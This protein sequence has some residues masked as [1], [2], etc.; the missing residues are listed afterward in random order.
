M[1]LNSL[2]KFIV[3]SRLKKVPAYLEDDFSNEKIKTVGLLIDE[4]YFDRKNELLADLKSNGIKEENITTVLYHDKEKKRDTSLASFSMKQ[5]SWAGLIEVK[6]VNS[7]LNQPFDLLIS[8]YDVEKPQLL[9]ITQ[10]SKAKC[11][12][13]FSSIDKK[14]NHLMIDTTAENNGIFISELFRYL[15]ILNKI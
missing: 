2:K 10:Q 15:K 9:Y 3:K 1:F 5:V 8:Y 12:A 6:E 4:T 13:G 7:F 14:R 11:K